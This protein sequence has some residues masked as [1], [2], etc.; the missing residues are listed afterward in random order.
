[1]V[2]IDIN[3]KLAELP[4]DI[5]VRTLDRLKITA[6]RHNKKSAFARIILM[7][8]LIGPGIL[9][10]IADN[11]AGGVVTYA[12]TGSVFGIGFFIPFMVLMIPVAYVVQEMT[13]R[14]AAVTRRGH[15]EMIWQ[16]YGSFW[17]AFSLIDLMVANSLTLVTE[18]IGITFGLSMF[19]VKPIYAVIFSILVVLTITLTLRYYKWER[20]SLTIAA[21]NLVFVPLVLFSHPNVG[22]V[23]QSFATWKINGGITS[24]FIY[25]LLANIG[26]TIAPWM[27]FFQQSAEV[28]KGTVPEDIKAARR[29]TLIGACVMGIVAISIIILTATLVYSPSIHPSSGYDMQYILTTISSKIGIIPVKLFALGLIEAGLIATIAITASTSW[30]VGEAFQWPKSIN[31]PF[32]Q[33]RKFYAPGMISLLIAAIIVLIPNISLGFLNLTVQVIASI[34]M[35]AALLFL[36]LLI[37]DKEIMGKYANTKFQNTAVISIMSVLILMSGLYGISLIFPNLF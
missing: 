12:Q 25:V 8:T 19:G 33:G 31:L 10:M 28:D 11:D 26:T 30:A 14:L 24:L 20:V 3:K 23:A 32:W 17:G 4:T 27:L 35:P 16:R 22:L 6:L 5:R 15:A 1:M 29:D 13:I 18:F 21:L 37:N 34:F 9:V 7:L 2:Q 36:L